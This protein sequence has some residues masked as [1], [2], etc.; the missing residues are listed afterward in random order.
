VQC[1]G[2]KRGRSD[3]DVGVSG[4]VAQRTILS[5]SQDVEMGSIDQEPPLNLT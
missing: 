3:S 5:D 4:V 1:E 2:V